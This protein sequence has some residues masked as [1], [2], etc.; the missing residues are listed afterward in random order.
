MAQC[1]AIHPTRNGAVFCTK[2]KGHEERGDL[3]HR[4]FRKRWT[5]QAPGTPPLAAIAMVALREMSQDERER[6]ERERNEHNRG[7]T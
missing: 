7:E 5:G 4:G 1:P 3:E 2:E 6:K